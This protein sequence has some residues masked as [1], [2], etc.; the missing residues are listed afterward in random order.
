M[1]SWTIRA[2]SRSP[3]PASAASST[4]IRA[5]VAAR[6]DGGA[7]AGPVVQGW[8]T[9]LAAAVVSS[10][11]AVVK[12]PE[13]TAERGASAEHVACAAPSAFTSAGGGGAYPRPLGK[14]AKLEQ[15]TGATCSLL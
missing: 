15:R 10:S 2:P 12:P 4:A 11:P 8:S 9:P 13:I 1:A 3:A 7:L 5:M 6:G 14:K